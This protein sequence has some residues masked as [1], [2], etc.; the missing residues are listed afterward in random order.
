MNQMTIERVSYG[1]DNTLKENREYK[2]VDG[3]AVGNV[4]E[5]LEFAK[6][7]NVERLKII[8][9]DESERIEEVI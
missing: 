5:W 8:D 2:L 1:S 9:E 6:N 4:S 3:G 7:N